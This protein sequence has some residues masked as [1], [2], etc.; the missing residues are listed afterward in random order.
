MEPLPVET[1]ALAPTAEPLVPDALHLID[2]AQQTSKI[3]A[4]TEVVEVPLDAPLERRVLFLY[5]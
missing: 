5:R 1:F 4:H 2:D 3:A